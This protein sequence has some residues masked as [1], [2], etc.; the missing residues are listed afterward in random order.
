MKIRVTEDAAG[1]LVSAFRTGKLPE[2]MTAI[3]YSNIK[4]MQQCQLR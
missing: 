3:R 4:T 1:D 2:P